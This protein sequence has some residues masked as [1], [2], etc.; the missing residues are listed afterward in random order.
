MS[1]QKYDELAAAFVVGGLLDCDTKAQQAITAYS[2]AGLRFAWSEGGEELRELRNAIARKIG[3]GI[4]KG[5]R[6]RLLWIVCGKNT[7]SSG[8]MA[9]NVAER[10]KAKVHS[11]ARGEFSSALASH[12]DTDTHY[13]LGKRTRTRIVRRSAN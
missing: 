2:K 1:K 11:N 13:G 12:D 6:K 9:A 4:S 8:K 5:Q 10:A 7:K 3:G